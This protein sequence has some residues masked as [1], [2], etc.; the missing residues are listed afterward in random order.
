MITGRHLE[1]I[2]A[3]LMAAA[4]LAV[5]LLLGNPALAEAASGS[6]PLYANLL[7][8]GE[9][10]DL[11]I[12]IEESSWQQMLENPL[13][14]EYTVC[15]VTINGTQIGNIGIR[16]KGNTS[17][18][19]VASTDSDRFSFKLEFDHYVSGQTW[20]G[21]DKLCLNNNVSDATLMKEY[22]TYDW[23]RQLGVDTPLCSYVKVSV[24]GEYWGLYL[25]VEAIEESYAARCFG[26][27]YGQLY[28]P[29]TMD[30]GGGRMDG[31]NGE[32]EKFSPP[33]DFSPPDTVSPPE[34]LSQGTD[35]EQPEMT[36]P[37]EMDPEQGQQ[38]VPAMGQE[39]PEDGQPFGKENGTAPEDK[40][41]I[42]EENGESGF[43]PDSR[44]N[45]R[46]FG[47]F[48]GNSG[49]ANL[50]YTDDDPESYSALFDSAVFD[51]DSADQKR[52]IE[53]LRQLNNGENLEQVVD[54]E[55]TL[56]YFAVSAFTVNLDSY[57]SSM[58]HNYYLYE[59][60]G[61]LTMLPW[62]FNLSF[63]GFQSGSA[64]SAVNFP[65]DTPVSGVELEDRP[66]LSKLLANEE[67]RSI[68]HEYLSQLA[69]WAED[70]TFRV[71]I[72]QLQEQL[73]PYMVED[74][75]AFY[76]VEEYNTAVDTLL[77][78]V[79]LR[80]QSVQGQLDGTIPSTDEGQNADPSL[81]VDASALD[82][83]VM[84]TQGGAGGMG[85]GKG[86]FDRNQPS[87][88]NIDFPLNQE[89]LP[90]ESS[91]PIPELRENNP[92]AGSQDLSQVRQAM[93][94]IGDSTL[95]ELS[96][97]QLAQLEELGISEEELSDLISWTQN[98]PDQGMR[99]FPSSEQET[100]IDMKTLLLTGTGLLLV[101]AGI[102]FALIFR[103]KR[104]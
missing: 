103:R 104:L 53:A 28:K 79:S 45:G 38:D 82:L 40:E 33:D 30:M 89:E 88:E 42:P 68:Y 36:S 95:S 1:K 74:P 16:T 44:E 51:I 20:L 52:L 3:L 85:G 21:L 11:D 22:L 59:E 54:V 86:G 67:Y 101:L 26:S 91:E 100:K 71:Q 55:K 65:I 2:V 97:S 15:N 6:T 83:T 29:E 70:N 96:E 25:G 50:V 62:D 66:L 80:G 57:L 8:Q 94:I 10:L 19:Q 4:I 34:G 84:G 77:Q 49:G 24:N 31:D 75:T 7:G 63:A 32:M 39:P 78:F 18:S 17:L 98:I 76:T 9:V 43:D 23:M 73:T 92:F 58:T 102:G 12:E 69:Q 64:D 93:E 81:L 72:V 61:Q 5:T 35:A 14:E 48:G 13:D 56:A 90:L 27:N 47:G 37:P 46:E 87:Q 41:A 60:D 99:A